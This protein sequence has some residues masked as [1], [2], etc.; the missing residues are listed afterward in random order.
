LEVSEKQF[1]SN[2]RI[3]LYKSGSKTIPI[4]GIEGTWSFFGGVEKNFPDDWTKSGPLLF[5]LQPKFV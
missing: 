4:V 5:L 2:I 3:P 1:E